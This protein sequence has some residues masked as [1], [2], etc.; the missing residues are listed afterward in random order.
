MIEQGQQKM[1]HILLRYRTPAVRRWICWWGGAEK[2][3]TFTKNNNEEG[4]KIQLSGINWSA[5]TLRI[6]PFR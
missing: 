5:E 4:I 1:L 6:S 2:K 3:G